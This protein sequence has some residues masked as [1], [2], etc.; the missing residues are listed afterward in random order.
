MFLFKKIMVFECQML[1]QA[2]WYLSIQINKVANYDVE[3]DQ[4][5]YCWSI[6]EW[7]SDRAGAEKVV[8]HDLHH[9]LMMLFQEYKIIH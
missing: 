5:W 3:I 2:H 6:M 4:S 7:I 9:Y 1:D 8:K